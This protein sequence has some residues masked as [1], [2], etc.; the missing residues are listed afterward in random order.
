LFGK[1][2][3]LVLDNALS[4]VTRALVGFAIGAA[5][6]FVLAMLMNLFGIVE[7]IAYPYLLISQMIPI[8]GVAPI[9]MA[10][11]RDKTVTQVV[12]GAFITFF[13]VCANV[14][15]GFKSVGDEKKALMFSYASN[16]RD[17]YVK[18]IVPSALG[19]LFAGMKIAAPMAIT[20]SII[21]DTLGS[22]TGIGALITYS[23]K[24]GYPPI[25]F[26]ASIVFSAALGILSFY[27]VMLAERLAMPYRYARKDKNKNKKGTEAAV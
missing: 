1:Y 16:K 21:V 20:A 10:L 11:F 14:L 6:G 3:G 13:P 7:K 15:A 4:T 9:F 8:L 24:G 2:F 27:A 25:V 23:L 12:I 22:A 17:L 19:S 18:L 5:I 26:W